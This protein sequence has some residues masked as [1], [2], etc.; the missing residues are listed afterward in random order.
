M[1]SG[2]DEH[3]DRLAFEA[4]APARVV[5]AGAT[6]SGTIAVA[7]DRRAWC[8]VERRPGRLRI[9][10][11]DT[12]ETAEA[13]TLGG[14]AV[15]APFKVERAIL[16][17]LGIE[18]DLHLV[19]QARV[20]AAAGLGVGGALGVAIASAAGRIVGRS[21]T[22]HEIAAIVAETAGEEAAH[23]AL[24]SLHGG[25][26][27]VRRIDG[28]LAGERLP[29]DPGRVEECLMLVDAGSARAVG[30]PAR[31]DGLAAAATAVARVR[32]AFLAARYDD[33]G[34]AM[35]DEWAWRGATAAATPE[36]DRIVAIVETAGGA[37]RPG[38]DGGVV[39]VWAPPGSRGPG[40]REAVLD[41]LG[42]QGLRP[43]RI[44]VDLRGVE[45]EAG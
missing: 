29:A 22:A 28:A 39:V 27:H 34:A 2:A 6:G 13:E 5:L 32:A 30:A 1:H 44:R 9:D 18:R 42:R 8:R 43:L 17:A 24:V 26:A 38:V 15:D 37:A 23:D 14:L 35:R 41:A 33:V 11:K 16:R 21:V 40:P 10:S 3:V 20:P 19:T 4:T 7:I 31:S 36:I 45:V 25:I 12:L